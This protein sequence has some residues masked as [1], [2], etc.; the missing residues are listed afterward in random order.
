MLQFIVHIN[1]NNGM[2]KNYTK[3]DLKSKFRLYF[4]VYKN[5]FIYSNLYDYGKI[6]YKKGYKYDK[7]SC[8]RIERYS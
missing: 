6:Q 7:F 3:Y 2:N 8:N 4:F 1:C 5:I